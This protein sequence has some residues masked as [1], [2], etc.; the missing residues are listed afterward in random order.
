MGS[1]PP[2]HQHRRG[3]HAPHV[4]ENIGPPSQE[5]CSARPTMSPVE[6]VFFQGEKDYSTYVEH[7]VMTGSLG[8]PSLVC[9]DVSQHQWR[10]REPG[11]VE[12]FNFFDCSDL[13]RASRALRTNIVVGRQGRTGMYKILFDPRLLLWEKSFPTRYICLCDNGE[14]YI[15]HECL[16]TLNIEFCETGYKPLASFP[17]DGFAKPFEHLPNNQTLTR[18]IAIR[19]FSDLTVYAQIKSR[20]FKPSKYKS[21]SS[22][23]LHE[24]SFAKCPG[25]KRG[26]MHIVLELTQQDTLSSPKVKALLL[27]TVP[28]IGRLGGKAKGKIEEEVKKLK[29]KAQEAP[30]VAEPAKKK[31]ALYRKANHSCFSK[32]CRFCTQVVPKLEKSRGMAG[33]KDETSPIFN[34]FSIQKNLEITHRA[35]ACGIDRLLPN[36]LG[37]LEQA[38][39][40]SISGWDIE[41]LSQTSEFPTPLHDTG[42]SAISPGEPKG[43]RRCGVQTPYLIGASI[44]RGRPGKEGLGVDDLETTFF[45][46]GC[47]EGAPPRSDVASMVEEFF[48]WL[49]Q[50]AEERRERKKELLAE[51]TKTLRKLCDSLEEACQKRNPTDKRAPKAT[52]TFLGRLLPQMEAVLSDMFVVGFNSSR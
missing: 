28:K 41:S 43:V 49:F 24:L 39:M 4:H 2:A 27:N 36:L 47:R 21:V 45:D 32:D 38:R 29:R 12:F 9:G 20:E 48:D 7:T 42:V 18:A 30:E 17:I 11:S 5:P 35:K 6:A 46:V 44:L 33:L 40:M 13:V 34:P 15:V 14:A 8:T 1:N 37:K 3:G 23:P 25:E 50:I 52:T 10:C 22:S 16:E 31:L 19:F 26:D 51:E